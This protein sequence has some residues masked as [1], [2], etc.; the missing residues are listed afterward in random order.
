[1]QT[2]EQVEIIRRDICKLGM[3][4]EI[5]PKD[6]CIFIKNKYPDF[7]FPFDWMFDQTDIR[8][9]KIRDIDNKLK[10]IDIKNFLEK[11]KRLGFSWL[12]ILDDEYPIELKSIYS[13]PL[14]LFYSGNI[15]YLKEEN[16][17]A[18]VGPRKCSD[19]GLRATDYLLKHFI[20]QFP[21]T[22]IVSG[23]AAGIDEQAHQAAIKHEAPTIAVIGTGLDRSYPRRNRELQE[24]MLDNELVLSE[25]PLHTKPLRHHFPDRNRIVAGLSR[26][27]L[28]AEARERS[29]SLITAQRALEEGRDVFAVPGSIF[30]ITSIGTNELIR[31]GAICV[32]DEKSIQEEW[33]ISN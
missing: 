2:L 18:V 6:K 30:S 28:V 5:S 13:P 21:K 20:K 8:T 4:G 26:G 24:Y 7:S 23:L 11:H 15:D 25:Y 1:M 14:L 22:P 27:V 19:Y 3:L 31:Q 9:D 29:G 32:K 17:L 16:K 12:T 33:E 10:K